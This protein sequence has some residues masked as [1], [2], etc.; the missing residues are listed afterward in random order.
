MTECIT[1]HCYAKLVWK[2]SVVGTSGE[3]PHTVFLRLQ[4]TFVIKANRINLSPY[5]NLC[6]DLGV[7]LTEMRIL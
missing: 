5:L 2:I 3:C 4:Q 1:R 6:Y 7:L